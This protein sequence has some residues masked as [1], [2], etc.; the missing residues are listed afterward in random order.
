MVLTP[1]SPDLQFSRE[2][3]RKSLETLLKE[4]ASLKRRA[5]EEAIH[6]TR[7]QSR[8]MRAALEAFHDLLA[9]HPY[10]AAYG[11]VRQITRT[12][13]RPR[14]QGVSLALLRELTDGGDM[15]ENLC[16][17]YLEERFEGRLRR[18]EQ[19][20]KQGLK[21]LDARR[22]RSQVEFLLAGMGP[23][24]TWDRPLPRRGRR[25][26]AAGTHPQPTLFPM[27][28]DP[29][30]RGRKLIQSLSEP[31][32]A[33]RAPQQFR[34]ASDERL[35]DIRIAAKKLRYAMEIFDPVWPKGLQPYISQAKALQDAGGHYHDWCVL[36][37]QLKQE[38]RRLNSRH[39]VHLTFQIGRLLAH[40]EDLKKKLRRLVL[41]ELTKLQ[42]LLVSLSSAAPPGAGSAGA[43]EH[44]AAEEII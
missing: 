5:S 37:E 22:L 16:R 19:R 43:G 28:E 21:G 1:D 4:L 6:D 41:P 2:T 14:E 34:R 23:Q 38:I 18:Q 40:A 27:H 31:I 3:L 25:T 10:K 13:G 30:N 32:L 9:P 35:H 29:R 24:E 15:A 8:R 26:A 33:F 36:C 20:L 7:V 12:L 17:E 42:V 39:T 44:S 11:S